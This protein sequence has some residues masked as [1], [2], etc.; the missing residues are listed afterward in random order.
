MAMVSAVTSTGI[1][2]HRRMLGARQVGG[3]V[4]PCLA[5]GENQDD[6]CRTD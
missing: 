3:V 6:Q 2:R 5:I 4:S 1:R